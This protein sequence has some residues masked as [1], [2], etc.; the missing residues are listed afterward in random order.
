MRIQ[1]LRYIIS[2]RTSNPFKKPEV[3]DAESS[4]HDNYI[5]VPADIPSNNIV[6]VCKNY[7]IQCLTN[8]LEIN[9]TTGNLYTS[10]LKSH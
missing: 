1:K 10:I 9:S 8:Q 3:V 7:H 5:V 2:T 4:V 6:L